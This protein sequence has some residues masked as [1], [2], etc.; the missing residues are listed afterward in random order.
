V[1][2]LH[3][4]ELPIAWACNHLEENEAEWGWGRYEK[5]IN[6]NSLP[7]DSGRQRVL[8]L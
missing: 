5:G 1:V 3:L 2:A 6:C 7:S 8:A 4:K